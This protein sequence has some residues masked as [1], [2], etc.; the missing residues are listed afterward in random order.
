MNFGLDDTRHDISSPIKSDNGAQRSEFFRFLDITDRLMDDIRRL[1]DTLAIEKDKSEQLLIEN[2]ELKIENNKLKLKTSVGTQ[3]LCGQAKIEDDAVNNKNIV[4]ESIT[5]ES[6]TVSQKKKRPNKRQRK[7]NKTHFDNTD[8]KQEKN[9]DGN[10]PK[11]LPSRKE[12]E[13]D[14]AEAQ[15]AS[16]YEDFITQKGQA[17]ETQW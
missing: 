9:R 4:F 15:V 7:N 8:N 5:I 6:D 10:P 12:S 17:L 16:A 1:H 3:P 2:C 11:V 13:Q 14:I